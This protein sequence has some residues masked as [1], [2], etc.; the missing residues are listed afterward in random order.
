[1]LT[2]RLASYSFGLYFKVKFHVL[3]FSSESKEKSPICQTLLLF[4]LGKQQ[5]ILS[6]YNMHSEEK[7]L[8]LKGFILS[9]I[10]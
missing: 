4:H 6:K 9:T 2:L 3:L 10:T 1:M 7:V 8:D 5:C